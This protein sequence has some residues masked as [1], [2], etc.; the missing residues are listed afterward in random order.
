LRVMQVRYQLRQRPHYLFF[1]FRGYFSS[2]LPT[3]I[4]P[5]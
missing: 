4:S 1:L 5:W 3:A 2:A